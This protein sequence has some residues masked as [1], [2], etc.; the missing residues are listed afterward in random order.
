VKLAAKYDEEVNG[1]T[2]LWYPTVSFSDRYS[3]RS[4]LGSGVVFNDE[5]AGAKEIAANA[6]RIEGWAKTKMREYYEPVGFCQFL[7]SLL[8][9]IESII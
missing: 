8:F 6:S 7:S 3:D 4:R 9:L 2:K 5:T 1:S